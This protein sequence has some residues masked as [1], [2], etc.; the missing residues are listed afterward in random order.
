MEWVGAAATAVVDEADP[1]SETGGE[2]A[3]HR[4]AAG[5]TAETVVGR[6]EAAMDP[7]VV[8]LAEAT[9]PA[10]TRGAAQM[11]VIEMVVAS[12]GKPS[13]DAGLGN[14]IEGNSP[15]LEVC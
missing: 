4:V 5:E 14:P 8:D 2:I 13:S 12:G 15:A 3:A 7:H 10:G 11:K 1:A 9:Q 6:V